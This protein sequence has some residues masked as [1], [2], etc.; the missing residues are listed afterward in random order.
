MVVP[1]IVEEWDMA[2][3]EEV[4]FCSFEKLM[5]DKDWLTPWQEHSKVAC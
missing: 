4:G 5:S 2:D 1:K 3:L